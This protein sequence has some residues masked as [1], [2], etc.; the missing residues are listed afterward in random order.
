M[1]DQD[2]GARGAAGA[3]EALGS[4]EAVQVVQ[5]IPQV[6]GEG[7]QPARESGRCCGAAGL[8]PRPLRSYTTVGATSASAACTG[9]QYERPAA[10]PPSKTTV[11]TFAGPASR[12]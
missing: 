12:W 11:G 6:V 5:Q 10:S 2:V 1:A 4:A 7:G 9:A 3:T 8:R